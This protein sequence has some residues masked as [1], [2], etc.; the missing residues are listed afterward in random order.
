M[1]RG[2]I[3][4]QGDAMREIGILG[5]SGL[6]TG[7]RTMDSA[8]R[9]LAKVVIIDDDLLHLEMLQAALANNSL[10]IFASQ[11]P[12][13]GLAL[14]RSKRP[15]IVLLDIFMPRHNG[16]EILDRIVE[17]DAGIDVIMMT[18]NYSAES[19]VEAIQKGA[20]DYLTKPLSIAKLR[21]RVSQLISDLQTHQLSNEL[22][23]EVLKNFE[24]EGMVGR[25]P[26][27][28]ELSRKIR[29][30]A[31][32]FRTVLV[33][34]ETGT[35]KELVGRALHRLSGSASGPFV[36]CNSSA[37]V[38]SLFET[39]LFGYVKGAFTGA[40]QDRAGVF[41][42][43]NGGTVMLDE[44]GE[45]SLT[46][47]A[48]IL[49]VLQNEEIQ[50][51]G[52]PKVIKVNV[53]VV[54]ST[55]RDLREMVAAGTFREDLY[56]RL[57]TVEL[58]VPT[59]SDRKEDLPLL[60]RHFIKSFSTRYEKPIRG[61]TRR[62]QVVLSRYSWPGN[63]RELENI[64]GHACMMAEGDAIDVRDLPDRLR[65]NTES[66][67]KQGILTLD[68]MERQYVREVVEKVGNKAQAAELLGIGRSTLYRILVEPDEGTELKSMKASGGLTRRA[69]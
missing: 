58:N 35:G 5:D 15:Q 3:P 69:S 38:E 17:F 59:L 47:Q 32:H 2:G 54:A 21:E 6:K 23:L 62:A 24:F 27:M 68:D 9:T 42:Y 39:E 25:S 26:L 37:I 11:D 31:P 1:H 7:D 52:S 44:I 60:Q 53:R 8:N 49:R 36:A 64:I 56:Y 13:Q 41:E 65:G 55:H 50:R 30:I 40:Q 29:R 67:R 12:E 18:G 20:A 19:A 63:I 43:A 57:S 34:G 48:K 66:P 46:A 14:I 45:L 33:M 4:Q 10:E 61:I 51:V 16:M 28:L 22:D